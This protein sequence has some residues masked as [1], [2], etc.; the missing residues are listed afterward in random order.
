MFFV[1][2]K[3]GLFD[4]IEATK[5][6]DWGPRVFFFSRCLEYTRA[7]PAMLLR[8]LLALHS[9]EGAAAGAPSRARGRP[10]RPP[11][12]EWDDGLEDALR[13]A[14][15][16]R[17]LRR[18][19]VGAVRWAVLDEADALLMPL[20]KYATMQQKLSRAAHPK[21]AATLLQLLSAARGPSL[22]LVAASATVGRPL[23]RGPE[24]PAFLRA[25]SW[26]L[27][28]CLWVAARERVQVLVG[29]DHRA[30]EVELHSLLVR[31][32]P[33]DPAG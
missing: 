12:D 32:W 3:R 22:Q 2:V 15:P 4:R 11:A 28:H 20:S 31:L 26:G 27:P 19:V 7:R 29:A 1:H 24:R 16:T 5:G 10:D 9:E 13:P 23:R 21:E 18:G 30:R 17:E 8:M 25:Q 6:I 33:R 14:P